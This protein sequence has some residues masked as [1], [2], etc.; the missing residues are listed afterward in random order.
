MIDRGTKIWK[1]I[2]FRWAEVASTIA[3]LCVTA[4]PGMDRLC[5]NIER[6]HDLLSDAVAGNQDW[7]KAFEAE[8]WLLPVGQLQN[9]A[10]A[11]RRCCKI[12]HLVQSKLAARVG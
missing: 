3:D 11:T 9:R 4:L 10:I 8:D 7:D 1:F 6:F 5:D 2:V 12:T